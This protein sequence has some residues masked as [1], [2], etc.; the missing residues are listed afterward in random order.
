MAG[1]WRLWEYGSRTGL[2]GA[3]GLLL[4]GSAAL[5]QDAT[6]TR[7]DWASVRWEGRRST[8]SDTSGTARELTLDAE[9]QEASR[10]LLQRA[11]PVAGA[12]TLVDVATGEVLA[13]VEVGDQKN[14]SLL[15]EPVAPA[16]SVFK[17][18]T[19]VA[20]YEH[21]S[22]TPTTR[23][24]TKGGIRSIQEEH[25]VPAQGDG[26]VCS[27]FGHALG[28]SR[29]A[30]YA[31]LAHRWLSPSDLRATAVRLGFNRPRNS[32]APGQLGSLEVPEEDL[33][34]ARTAAGFENSK[35]SV[36]GGA[37]LALTIA[38]GGLSRPLHFFAQRED[39]LPAAPERALRLMSSRAADRVRRSMEFTVHSG[40]AHEAFRDEDGKPFLGNIR[41]AGK[42]GTRRPHAGAPTA[43]WFIGFAP[44]DQ[45]RVAVSVVLQNSDRWHQKGHQLARDV[46]RV[47]FARNKALGVTS[48][49]QPEL[50]E[51]VRTASWK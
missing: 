51:A 48:P 26:V 44:S 24:C 49:V 2:L 22:I 20:L 46:L 21:S 11:K 31:Q 32:D 7:V 10:L 45:P 5:A 40:T 37:E 50:Q 18:V 27:P 1:H 16:A 9:L 41:V 19:T 4:V 42:T 12:A 13:A 6:P 47:Y 38:S 28:V 8:A 29:N 17:I 25:L 43:S 33:H 15:F 3:L 36:L 23:V 34:Y 30:A 14:G 39:S 35:L